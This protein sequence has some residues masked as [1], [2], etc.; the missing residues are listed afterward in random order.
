MKSVKDIIKEK[1][2]G[3]AFNLVSLVVLVII[4][5]LV[6]YA[7][8]AFS[9]PSSAPD[10]S[11]QDFNQN[12][13][14]ANNANNLFDSSS[15][16][17]NADGSIIER[18]EHL[19]AQLSPKLSNI[20]AT[21]SSRA[22]DSEVGNA[23]D[24]ANIGTTLFAGQQYLW[25][26]RA[27]FGNQGGGGLNVYK[28]DGTTLVGKFLGFQ[29]GAINC[30]SISY[31]DANGVFSVLS[32]FKCSGS[33]PSGDVYFS[34]DG[35]VGTPYLY[36]ELSVNRYNNGHYYSCA[37]NYCSVS[38]ESKRAANGNCSDVGGSMC[39]YISCSDNGTVA[40]LCGDGLCK[41]K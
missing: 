27:S 10:A 8:A 34:S 9:E 29:D 38:I 41:I 26:N 25:D 5:L 21:V 11:N 17:A 12:I 31:S 7:F 16:A 13:L 22:L 39:A 24:A 37:G 40:P 15:V 33:Y 18:L 19:W 2:V 35:C 6:I 20:D 32:V 30:P 23:S 1:A 3:F 4:L 14:G 28:Y 36:Q